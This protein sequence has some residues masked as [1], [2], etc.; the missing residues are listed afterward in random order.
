MRTSIKNTNIKNY[1]LLNG[2]N[3]KALIKLIKFSKNKEIIIFIL[4]NSEKTNTLMF[5]R[6]NNCFSYSDLKEILGQ[7]SDPLIIGD[8]LYK[9]VTI[10]Y[11]VRAHLLTKS[12][13]EGQIESLKYAMLEIKNQNCNKAYYSISSGISGLVS[14]ISNLMDK[15]ILKI[16]VK[17]DIKEIK[18]CAENRLLILN[19][20]KQKEKNGIYYSREKY[21]IT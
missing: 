18:R 6:H 1:N 14:H 5:A 10:I 2:L 20:I 12:F 15:E 9:C 3:G 17:S 21:R 16:F 4:K 19:K 11:N 13:T 7:P 8:I